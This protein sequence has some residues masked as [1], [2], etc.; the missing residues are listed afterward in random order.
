MPPTLCA[1][2]RTLAMKYHPDKTDGA[3]EEKVS[4]FSAIWK[5]PADGLKARNFRAFSSEITWGL[6]LSIPV[7]LSGRSF[8]VYQRAAWALDI[9]WSFHVLKHIFHVSVH[10]LF[11]F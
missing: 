5:F 11:F 10:P 8:L 7:L 4:A 1:A 3:T 9:G 6:C 2:Y